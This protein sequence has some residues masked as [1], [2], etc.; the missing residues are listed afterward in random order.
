MISYCPDHNMYLNEVCPCCGKLIQ[1][2]HL[3]DCSLCPYC[4]GDLKG[5]GKKRDRYEVDPYES[6]VWDAVTSLQDESIPFM[7]T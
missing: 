1:L 5:E 3:R 4:R 7:N 2:M 6:F